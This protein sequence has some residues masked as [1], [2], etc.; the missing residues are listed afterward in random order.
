MV[1]FQMTGCYAN[2]LFGLVSMASCLRI[3]SSRQRETD[4]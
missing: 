2:I 3:L 4:R 1:A